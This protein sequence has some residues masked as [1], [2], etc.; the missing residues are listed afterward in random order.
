MGQGVLGGAGDGL[1]TIALVTVAF[2][3][4]VGGV[5]YQHEVVVFVRRHLLERIS[6]PPEPPAGR[7]IE[8]IASDVRRVRHEFC[9]PAPGMPMARRVAISRAYDDL[10][11][12]ACRAL[13]VPDTLTGLPPGTDRD[14]ERLRVEHELTRAGLRLTA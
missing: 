1:I 8:R 4:L 11:V 2:G 5:L 12:A 7:P 10:L 3:A 13:D 6:P 14:A 9:R